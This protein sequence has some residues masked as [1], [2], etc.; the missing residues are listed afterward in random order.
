[1]ID[2][3]SLNKEV[4]DQPQFDNTLRY[5]IE[6]SRNAVIIDQLMSTQ[7]KKIKNLNSCTHSWKLCSLF[8]KTQ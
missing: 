1:M 3:H 4:A 7:I 2:R 6:K 8:E 5:C